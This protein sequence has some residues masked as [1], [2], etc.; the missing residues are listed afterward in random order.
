MAS[1]RYHD[2]QNKIILANKSDQEKWKKDVHFMTASRVEQSNLFLTVTYSGG[3]KKHNFELVAWNYFIIKP[4]EIQANILLSHDS[5]SDFCKSIIKKELSF[6]L[7]PLKSEYQKFFQSTSGTIALLLD[8][9]K[10]RYEF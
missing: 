1:A 2:Q 4:N 9:L 10:V 7:S 6:D 5:N 3:C 8:N